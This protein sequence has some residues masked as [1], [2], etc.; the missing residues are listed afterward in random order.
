MWQTRIGAN[1]LGAALLA[2]FV[3]L[4]AAAL[5]AVVPP[6]V[7]VSGLPALGNVWRDENP[8]RGNTAAVAL[9][10]DAFDQACSRCHGADALGKGPAPNL[11]RLTRYCQRIED[12]ELRQ[13][14]LQDTDAYFRNAVLNGKVKVGVVH[15]PAWK[16]VLSQ[17]VLWAL[18]TYIESPVR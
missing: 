8:Y 15:M 12:P 18:K 9:G 16:G 17:E 2:T 11:R 4:P 13:A 5:E 1:R 10:Q 3:A 6:T 14:C 7:D